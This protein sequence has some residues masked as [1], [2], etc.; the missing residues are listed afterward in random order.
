V[1]KFRWNDECLQ[2]AL[3]QMPMIRDRRSKEEV[4]EQLMKA[5][6]TARLKTWFLPSLA[7]VVAV[8]LVVIISAPSLPFTGQ[9]KE[10]TEKSDKR[11]VTLQVEQRSNASQPLLSPNY[12]SE[13]PSRIITKEVL[14][15]QDI[16][17]VGLPDKQAQIV[18]PVS[19]PVKK[20]ESV[21]RQLET[22]QTQIDEQKWGVSKR[23][24]NGVTMAPS[25]ESKRVWLVRVSKQ[26]P[27]FSEGSTSEMM[28]LSSIEETV[29]WMGGK[30]IRFFTENKEGM[31]LSHTGYVK[32]MEIPN[33]KR[34]YYLYQLGPSHPVF[35]VPSSRHFSTFAEALKQMKKDADALLRSAIPQGV[36]IEKVDVRQDDVV[37][38][39]SS[40]LKLDASTSAYWMVEAI[41][42]TAREFGFRTVTFM[43]GN[44]KRIGPYVFGKK[45]DVPVGPNPVAAPLLAR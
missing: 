4:Y 42:L 36:Q 1:K 14:N 38:R 8:M 9:T 25:R 35:L 24:L 37:V 16:A 33:K 23:L 30:K 31:K 20:H 12:Y 15:D 10:K 19:V 21:R 29:R 34:A 43:G 17:V 26:N 39:F 32:S 6:K 44:V 45:I 5:R 7:S 2:H 13:I 11:I 22:A 40:D 28:F 41:L 27:V 18:I 3:Q